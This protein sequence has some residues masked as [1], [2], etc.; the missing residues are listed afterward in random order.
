MPILDSGFELSNYT[1][2]QGRHENQ[3]QYLHRIDRKID[4]EFHTNLMN[5]RRATRAAKI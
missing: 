2:H 1:A 3:Q 4:R 5:T